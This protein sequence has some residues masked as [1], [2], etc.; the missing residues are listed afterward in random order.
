MKFK[1]HG[2]VCLCKS[3]NTIIPCLFFSVTRTLGKV[4]GTWRLLFTQNVYEYTQYP[5]E[6][7]F[8]P[9]A[10]GLCDSKA[11]NLSNPESPPISGTYRPSNGRDKTN[12][13]HPRE[14]VIFPEAA[15]TR[16]LHPRKRFSSPSWGR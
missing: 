1:L 11:H 10:P 9:R 16:C 5:A 14:T 6:L 2:I 7:G 15:E 3:L 8:K 4:P 13:L 12:G